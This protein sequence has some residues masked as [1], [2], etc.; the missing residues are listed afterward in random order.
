MMHLATT[1]Y[2]RLQA[3]GP[4][5]EIL[6]PKFVAHLSALERLIRHW[7]N[8]LTEDSSPRTQVT[9]TWHHSIG[10]WSILWPHPVINKQASTNTH[11]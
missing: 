11:N 10:T 3:A 1:L 9:L 4:N 6:C 8:V 7:E 5:S 2:K